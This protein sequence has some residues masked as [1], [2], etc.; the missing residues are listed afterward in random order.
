M[1]AGQERTP[2]RSFDEAAIDAEAEF[3]HGLGFVD[4]GAR[5]KFGAQVAKDFL[6]GGEDAAIVLAASGDIEQA[7]QNALGA[8]ANGVVEISGNA[9]A[10]EDGGDVGAFDFGKYGRDGLDRGCGLGVA[11]VKERAHE[12]S[13]E[14]KLAQERVGVNGRG[15]LYPA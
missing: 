14:P 15:D 1:K 5:E 10:D 13:P 11:G 9:L 12:G 7:E 6:R 3:G 4:V 2:L 8:D